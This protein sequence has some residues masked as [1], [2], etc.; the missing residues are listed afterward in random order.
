VHVLFLFK[1]FLTSYVL[2]N[3]LIGGHAY[4]RHGYSE[5]GKALRGE[6]FLGCPVTSG[7]YGE[8]GISP[9]PVCWFQVP[10]PAGGKCLNGATPIA[11][12]AA[13][14]PLLQTWWVGFGW[15]GYPGAKAMGQLLN[16]NCAILLMP[17][18]HS[19]I[20][21]AHDLT[22]IYGPP[23]LRALSFVIPFD[24]AVVFHKACA[25]YFILPFVT[26]HAVL[27]YFNYGKSDTQARFSLYP[28]PSEWLSCR[29]VVWPMTRLHGAGACSL[30][31]TCA[32]LVVLVRDARQGAH[33][34]TTPCSVRAS[35]QPRRRRL[36]GGSRVRWHMA[37]IQPRAA[38][39]DC[40]LT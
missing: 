39:D 17:V 31:V 25:K 40:P 38:M 24:K 28:H 3:L 30:A 13:S 8:P 2:I 23:W 6:A 18:T 9:L 11:V 20:T 12:P 7:V 32:R 34:T 35:T 36:R 14:P 33:R 16:L 4:L 1:I 19:M 29:F 5:K 27:H 37:P 10:C 26:I 15:V 22:S 21:R